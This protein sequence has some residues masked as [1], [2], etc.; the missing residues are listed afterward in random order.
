LVERHE[1]YGVPRPSPSHH[2]VPSDVR[3]RFVRRGAAAVTIALCAMY[4][5]L[6][7]ARGAERFVDQVINRETVDAMRAGSGYYPAMDHALRRHG[8]SVSSVRAIRLPEVFLIWRLM[9]GPR[10]VWLLFVGLVALTA[11]L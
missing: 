1:S 7:P 11:L 8:G 4:A 6:P 9:P 2:L 3:S 10:A 5:V